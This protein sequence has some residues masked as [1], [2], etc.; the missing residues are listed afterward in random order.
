MVSH[1]DELREGDKVADIE[2]PESVDLV[3]A[4]LVTKAVN[5]YGA[6]HCQDILET[7]KSKNIERF[8]KELKKEYDE[9]DSDVESKC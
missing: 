1:D 2:L 8:E 6:T 7:I 3:Q 9:I 5:I 4:G